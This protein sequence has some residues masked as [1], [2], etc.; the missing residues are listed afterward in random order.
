MTYTRWNLVAPPV[1][2]NNNKPSKLLAILLILIGLIF[3]P[4]LLGIPLMV[5]GFY[6]LFK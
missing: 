4:L 2:H 1:L 6:K 3:S 5:W